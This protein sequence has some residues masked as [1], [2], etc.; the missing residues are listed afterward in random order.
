MDRKTLWAAV[1]ALLVATV[2]VYLPSIDGEFQYDDQEIAKTTWVREGSRF[3][4]VE[5]WRTVARPLTGATF[6]ANHAM[7]G[8]KPRVWHVTNVAIHLVAVLLVW[9]L[10]RALLA[11]A[12]LRPE[13]APAMESAPPGAAPSRGK[14][15]RKDPAA[16]APAAPLA[17]PEWTALAAAALFAL[18]PLH[19]EAVSYISQRSE[20]LASAFYVG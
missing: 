14:Q 8:F 18:H 1:A 9:R 6:A 19:T 15:K 10:A 16:P 20:A 11:R 12:G 4:G 17:V 13:G 7:A 5:A 2:A 3:L